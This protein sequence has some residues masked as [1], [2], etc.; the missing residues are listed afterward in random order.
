MCKK[1]RGLIAAIFLMAASSSMSESLIFYVGD[2]PLSH[3]EGEQ[4]QGLYFDIVTALFDDMA[5]PY[6]VTTLPFKRALLY[7]YEGRGIVVGIFKTTERATKLDFSDSFYDSKVVLFVRRGQGFPLTSVADLKGKRIATKLGWSYGAAFDEARARS[8][9]QTFDGDSTRNFRLIIESRVDAFIDNHLSGLY[10]VRK[11]DVVN[12]IEVLPQPIDIG[13]HYLGVKK[14]SRS[15]L[16]K[17]FNQHL[18]IFKSDGRYQKIVS[19][20]L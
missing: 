1:I 10:T 18:E 2:P 7:A 16:I 17:R 9:F 20:Y 6:E 5:V 14:N 3:A 12:K 15:G 11:M 8:E 19:K 4:P 13:P